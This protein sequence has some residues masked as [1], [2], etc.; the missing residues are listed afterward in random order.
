[1]IMG[2]QLMLIVIMA[3]D[4]IG[5]RRLVRITSFRLPLPPWVNAYWSLL[6]LLLHGN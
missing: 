5:C 3:V 1:M 2:L 4:G 6:R